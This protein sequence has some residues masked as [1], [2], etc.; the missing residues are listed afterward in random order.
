MQR[1]TDLN[2]PELPIEHPQ[3]GVDPLSAVGGGANVAAVPR[4][5]GIAYSAHCIRT[6]AG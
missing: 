3:F 5:V 2:V 4:S 6:G 1:I